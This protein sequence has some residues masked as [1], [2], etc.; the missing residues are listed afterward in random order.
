MIFMKDHRGKCFGKFH[1]PT[2]CGRCL[3]EGFQKYLNSHME[4][5][6]GGRLSAVADPEVDSG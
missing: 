1:T 4:N 6:H 5:L 2:G 3:K